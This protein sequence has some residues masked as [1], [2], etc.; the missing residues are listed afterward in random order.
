MTLGSIQP[1]TELITRN[2]SCGKRRPV[3]RADNLHVPIVLKCGNLN[4]L[5]PSW[6]V[7]AYNGIALPLP[8]RGSLIVIRR[9]A[10]MS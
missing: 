9:L 8:L 7:K 6:P 4:L 5:E 2:I 3:L 1:L 10:R